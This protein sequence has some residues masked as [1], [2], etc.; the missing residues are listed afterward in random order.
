MIAAIVETGKMLKV[1]LYSL[2]AGV[3][4]AVV[5]GAGVSGAASLLDALREHR[6]VAGAAWGVL[7]VICLVVAAAVIV[8]GVVVMTT[9]S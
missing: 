4:I 9:K 1:V 5:F 6:T 7:T 8:L 2:I 3:G